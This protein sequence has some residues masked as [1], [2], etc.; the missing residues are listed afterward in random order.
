MYGQGFADSIIILEI[1]AI[2]L[3]AKADDAGVRIQHAAGAAEHEIRDRI[4][5][6]RTVKSEFPVAEGDVYGVHLQNDRFAAKHE[7]MGASQQIE[8]VGKLV[9]IAA[10]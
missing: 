8:V 3:L 5:G 6:Q 2:V 9:L 4:V 10:E 7:V 1:E